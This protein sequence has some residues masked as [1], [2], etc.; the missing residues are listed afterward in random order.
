MV[1][2]ERNSDAGEGTRQGNQSEKGAPG[3][4]DVRS[5]AEFRSGHIPGAVH[6][7][8]WA[9]PLRLKVLPA[10][11]QAKLV[12]TCEHGPRAQLAKTLLGLA[13]YRNLE[14]LEGH[15]AG[16]RRAALPLEK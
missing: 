3:T 7:P 8:F 6:V 11:R 10:D 16:W 2:A 4:V 5:G 9:A 14:L 15:M 1:S 13:G 12:L